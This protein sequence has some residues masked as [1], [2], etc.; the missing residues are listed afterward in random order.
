M[1]KLRFEF[2]TTPKCFWWEHFV[3]LLLLNLAGECGKLSEFNLREKMT[4]FVGVRIKLNFPLILNYLFYFY[5]ID[6]S[7][8]I[9]FSKSALSSVT[10][11]FISRT[12]ESRSIISKNLNLYR[13]VDHLYKSGTK[14]G[15]IQT[16]LELQN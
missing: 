2:K 5:G 4:S 12:F 10:Y 1:L 14:V 15:L 6:I 16:P 9:I 3:I 7:H 8:W 13:Q 11:L